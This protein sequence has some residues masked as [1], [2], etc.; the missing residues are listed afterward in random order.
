VASEGPVA[1][2]RYGPLVHRR[3]HQGAIL[4]IVGVVDFVAANI[5]T[6]VGWNLHPGNPAYSLTQNYISDLGAVNCGELAG[7]Y[8]CS[9]WHLVF[10]AGIVLAGLLFIVGAILLQTAFPARLTRTIGLGL[11]VVAGIGSIGVGLSPEDVN[12]TVHSASALTAF[13][14][15]NLGLVVL[16]LAMFRDTRWAGYRAFSVICGLVGFVALL[17]FIAKAWAWGG[18][19]AAWGAGG[20]ERLVVAPFLLWALLAGIHLLRIRAFAPRMI[21][22]AGSG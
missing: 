13:L 3:V 16:G 11:I 1:E 22:G 19:F 18:F 15:A 12:I 8:V 6:Q 14:G 17:L 7:R 9:P 20:I 2:E 5:I 4:W 21:P 10:N